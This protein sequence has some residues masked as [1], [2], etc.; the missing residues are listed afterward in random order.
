[1][2]L[3]TTAA[4]LQAILIRCSRDNCGHGLSFW[5]FLEVCLNRGFVVT[6]G[7]DGLILERI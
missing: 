6:G 5:R 7:A 4:R 1:M 2:K 3:H